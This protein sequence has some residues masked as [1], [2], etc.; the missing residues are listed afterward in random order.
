MQLFSAVDLPRSIQEAW[1]GLVFLNKLLNFSL[2]NLD[3]L[4]DTRASMIVLLDD[5]N[6]LVSEPV[7]HVPYVFFLNQAQ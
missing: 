6:D 2:V 4:L 1:F 7:F 3:E 5:A